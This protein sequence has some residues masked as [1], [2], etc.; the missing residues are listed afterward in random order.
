MKDQKAVIKGLTVSWGWGIS[1]QIIT[2]GYN[3]HSEASEECF[4]WEERLEGWWKD[5]RKYKVREG[6]IGKIMTCFSWVVKDD[7]QQV[8][9]RG[10][11]LPSQR[12]SLG[13]GMGAWERDWVKVGGYSRH[14]VWWETGREKVG[15]DRSRWSKTPQ[16]LLRSLDFYLDD[17]GESLNHFKQEMGKIRYY[18]IL[19]VEFLK[20]V[21]LEG[22]HDWEKAAAIS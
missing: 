3:D 8:R 9:W 18:R 7:I 22:R 13:E 14:E 5:W 6:F 15:G 4:G 19:T 12:Q 20:V 10:L 1:S 2:L 16:V 17:Y 11:G 21:N